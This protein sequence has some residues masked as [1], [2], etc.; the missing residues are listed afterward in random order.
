VFPAVVG[1]VVGGTV[2]AVVVVVGGTVVGIVLVVVGRVVV[3]VV[4]VVVVTDAVV[5]VTD[6]VVAAGAVPAVVAGLVATL[7]VVTG[8]CVR[9]CNKEP[10]G[11]DSVSGLSAGAA[12]VDVDGA[13]AV[14]VGTEGTYSCVTGV[15]GSASV[16]SDVVCR[17]KSAKAAKAAN[18]NAASK[19][20]TK[21]SV[22]LRATCG[23]PS[24]HG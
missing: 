3:V 10:P 6:A 2:V 12:V 5:V 14:V 16:G 1:V 7:V 8:E 18:A 11:N 22:M 9:T 24:G 15:T 13:A 23:L 21:P 19:H 4:W 17:E 20:P